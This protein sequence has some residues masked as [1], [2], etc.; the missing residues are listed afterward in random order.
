MKSY[1]VISCFNNKNQLLGF[2]STWSKNNYKG[3][4]RKYVVLAAPT[5]PYLGHLYTTE[6]AAK[7]NLERVIKCGHIEDFRKIVTFK[8]QKMTFNFEDIA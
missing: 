7:V 1:F 5:V 3:E 8:V 4:D 6:K 2:F